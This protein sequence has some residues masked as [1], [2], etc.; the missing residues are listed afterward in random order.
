[1]NVEKDLNKEDTCSC[2]GNCSCG[3]IKFFEETIEGQEEKEFN[4]EQ[5][6]DPSSPDYPWVPCGI[7]KND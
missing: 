4:V 1:M 3:S 5:P 7:K 6:C 2:G